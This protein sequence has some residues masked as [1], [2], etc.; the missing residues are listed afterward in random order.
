[1]TTHIIEQPPCFNNVW[2]LKLLQPTGAENVKLELREVIK[3]LQDQSI[4]TNN[5]KSAHGIL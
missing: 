3:D 4:W 1:M 5:E 2:Y